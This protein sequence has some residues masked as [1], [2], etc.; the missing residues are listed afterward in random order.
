MCVVPPIYERHMDAAL[1]GAQE[2][3][4]RVLLERLQLS[5]KRDVCAWLSKV[6]TR[7]SKAAL[8]ST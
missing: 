6:V 1:S 5:K 8:Q 2:C 4:Q 7:L 3:R